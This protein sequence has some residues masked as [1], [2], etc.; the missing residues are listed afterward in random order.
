MTSIPVL[1]VG[2]AALCLALAGC[3]APRSD[4]AEIPEDDAGSQAAP[5][6]TVGVITAD[7]ASRIRAAGRVEAEFV[8]CGILTPEALARVA[9]GKRRILAPGVDPVAHDALYDIAFSQSTQTYSEASAAQ[10]IQT[11]QRAR[12]TAAEIAGMR[13]G[14]TSAPAAAPQT[15]LEEAQ[16]ALDRIERNRDG[17]NP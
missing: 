1:T 2:L 5:T 9:P 3:T 10:Q 17:R 15:S 8:A 11:C 6:S 16:A 12:A 4:T 13:T 7:Q 14:E